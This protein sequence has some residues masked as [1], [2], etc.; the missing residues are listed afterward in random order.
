MV[1][2]KKP[3]D[4]PYKQHQVLYLYLSKTFFFIYIRFNCLQIGVIFWVLEFNFYMNSGLTEPAVSPHPLPTKEEDKD[5]IVTPEMM[6]SSGPDGM[7]S[8]VIRGQG[9]VG[10]HNPL[11]QSRL[12]EKMLQD[13]EVLNRF[14]LVLTC[15]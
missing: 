9:L 15:F 6:K 3:S 5:G 10:N 1:Q 13:P 7:L 11:D 4:K 12:K 8:M 14:F 2:L